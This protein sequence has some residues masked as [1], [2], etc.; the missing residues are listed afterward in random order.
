MNHRHAVIRSANLEMFQ[1]VAG[2]KL[3]FNQARTELKFITKL[4]F[5]E[6]I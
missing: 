1:K 2:F 6:L 5:Y 4:K 3:S